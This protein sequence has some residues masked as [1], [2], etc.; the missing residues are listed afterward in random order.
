[1]TNALEKVIDWMLVNVQSYINKYNA[2]VIADLND[3]ILMGHSAAAHPTTQYLNSTCGPVKLQILLDPVDGVDPFGVV[4]EYITHPGQLLPYS[5]PVLVVQTELDPV[6]ATIAE[7]PCAADNI[8]NIRYWSKSIS[9]IT[10]PCEAQNG[11]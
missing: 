9:G 4:K 10:M 6:P 2:G 8:S 11:S 1:M 5:T 7:P 3:L